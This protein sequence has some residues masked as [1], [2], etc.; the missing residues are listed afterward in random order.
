MLEFGNK[1]A[2]KVCGVTNSDDALACAAA[3][4]EML[5]LNFSTESS[6]CISPA[7]ATEIIAAVRPQSPR[8]KFVGVFVNQDLDLVRAIAKD[9]ALDAIQLHGAESPEYVRDLRALF[10]IK[11]LRVGPGYSA[12]PA[13]DYRCDAILLDNWSPNAPGGTGETFPWP[14]A[15]ALRPSVKRLMLAGGLTCENV[16]AAVRLVRP[17][18]VDVCSG[19][20]AAPG[21]KNHAMLGRFVE[22]VRAADATAIAT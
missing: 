7:T 22:A 18:A 8:I 12:S 17:F 2:V 10:V 3:G 4:V 14:V 5:G 20:E 1:V 15:A 19:V 21:R 9:L 13:S 16:A 6:R 11:A